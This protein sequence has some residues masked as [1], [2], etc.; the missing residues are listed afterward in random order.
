MMKNFLVILIRI[1]I[2]VLDKNFASEKNSKGNRMK[3]I[4]G[5][6]A[7][8]IALAGCNDVK[9]ANNSNFEKV[10]NEYLLKEKDKIVCTNVGEKFPITDDFGIQ[11]KL[12]KEYVDSGLMK[13]MMEEK[14]GKELF[15]GKKTIS[16][17]KIYDLTEKGK[18]YIKDG[19]FCFGTPVVS[20]VISFTEPTAFM[21][22]T[23][24]EVKYT[25]ILKDLPSWFTSQEEKNKKILLYL[26]N[27]GWEYK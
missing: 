22:R 21:D 19:K 13:E 11:E 24:S 6:L 23:V 20:K 3:I 1:I 25:Y 5:S 14:E 7:L 10:I 15:T 16:I 2:K 27:N 12:F 18:E 26:T 8:I 4:L 17:I 9:D